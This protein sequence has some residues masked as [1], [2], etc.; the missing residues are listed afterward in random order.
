MALHEDNIRDSD[1][2]IIG[3]V[4][5]FPKANNVEALWNNLRD[6]VESISQFSDAELIAAGIDPELLSQPNYVKANGLLENVDL[7][8]AN[9]FGFSAKEAEIVDPQH[10]LFLECAW[11][12]LENAGYDPETYQGA[13][14]VYAGTGTNSYL[15][16]NLVPMMQNLDATVAFQVF[17]GNDKDFVAT[18]TSYKLNLK[19]P[20]INVSTAC[21]TSLV[22]VH[23]AS[24]S[25]LS[26]ECDMVLVGGVSVRVP[27]KTGYLY[28]QGMIYSPDGHC[29]AFD[30]QS[31][32]TIGGNGVG[33]I[34]LKRLTE[35]IADG[36]Y[37]HAVIKGSAINNDG[38]MK[39]GYTAPSVEGQAAVIAEAQAIAEVDADTITYIEAHGTA[40]DLGDPIEIAA[41]TK[42][43]QQSTDQ[44]GFC[45]IG[46]LK[47]NVGHLDAAAGIAGVIKTVQALKHKQI[48][49]SLHF[50]T[51]NPKIDFANSPFYVNA[52][53][54]EWEAIAPRRAGVS[55]FGI[56]GTNA[57]VI[58]EEAPALSPSGES[59]PYQLL[60]LSAKTAT[61]LNQAQANL[62]SYLRAT[63]DALNLA[64]IAFT[65]KVGRQ[66][67]EHRR[68]LICENNSAKI[69][70]AIAALESN[71]LQ[72]VLSQF[73]DLKT[74]PV[75]MMFSGQ[76][77][78]YVGMGQELYRHEPVFQE[79]LDRCCDL[80]IPHLGLDLRQILYPVAGRTEE[81]QQ[82]LQQTAI[83]QPAI[84]AIEY[85]LAQLWI[86]W[87]VKPQ[88]MIGHSIGEYVAAC[89]AQVFDLED[90]IKLVAAR[91]RLM[92]QLPA[93]A[94]LAVSLSATEIAPFLTPD[95]AIA[96]INTPSSTV[97][98]G[99]LEA[100]ANLEKQL[101]AKELN[102]R[103]LH[104]SHAFH[105]AMMEPMLPDFL[106]L[107]AKVNLHPPQIPYVSNVTG[108]WITKTEA[109]D[110]QYW[111]RHIRQT[112]KFAEGLQ[113]ILKEPQ[114]LL[115]EVG[116][117][118]TLSTLARQQVA[119]SPLNILSSLPHPQDTQSDLAFLFTTLGQLWL[120][121]V[122]IDWT[123]FYIDEDRHRIPLPT[124]PFERQ[125][126]WI[127]PKQ[128]AIALANLNQSTAEEIRKPDIS[129]WFYI[130]AWKQ[131]VSPIAEL[132]LLPRD[133]GWL[134]FVDDCQLSDLLIECLK[135]EQ[136]DITTVTIGSEFAKLGDRSYSINPSQSSN[137][138]NLIRE[139]RDNLQSRGKRL[140]HIIHLWNVNRKQLT[141][142]DVLK[143]EHQVLDLGLHSLIF[144]TQALGN[145]FSSENL[146]IVV[147]SN[148][149]QEVTGTENLCPEKATLLGAV[150]IVPQEYPNIRCRSVDITLGA[151][152]QPNAKLAE[153][154]LREIITP[155]SDVAI[156]YRGNYRW[157]QQFEPRQFPANPL[158]ASN[159]QTP[160]CR[161]RESGV[162]LI[163]GGMGGMGLAFAKYLA[164]TAK[165]KLILIGRS[166]FPDHQDWSNWL[167]TRDEEDE[168]SQKI[169]QL[170]S[171]EALGAE[172][173]AISADVSNLE[174]MQAVITQAE[175]RFGK[176]NG[177]LHAAGVPDYG[178]VIARRDRTTIAP[179]L[180]PKFRGT[181]VLDRLLQDTQLDFLLLCSS[182]SSLLHGIKFG[183]VS[184]CAANDFLDAYAYAKTA[185]DSTFTV[186]IN[187]TDW[188][189]VGMSVNAAKRSPKSTSQN[190]AETMILDGPSP[191]EGV[192]IFKRVLQSPSPRV[193]ISTQDLL[194]LIERYQSLSI[195]SFQEASEENTSSQS[196]HPRPELANAYV[197]PRNQTEQA[198]AKIWQQIIGVDRVGIYDNFFELGGDSLIGLQVIAK[199]NQEFKSNIPVATLYKAPTVGTI[200]EVVN[201]TT[202]ESDPTKQRRDRG[203]RRR[204]KR[205]QK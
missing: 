61:A 29:R 70:E 58:L 159:Y 121:G 3:I 146:D 182:L 25:L 51:P 31:Q 142:D 94:M 62:A 24:Q 86:S 158:T 155:T 141:V 178:G 115:L 69:Q 109:T 188:K 168:T 143:D 183:E 125:S 79:H 185:R 87:G 189:E 202:T 52:K 91:G 148:D 37:I 194:Q 130:P 36:D 131:S 49:P 103:R 162:Y 136:Q 67:F 190:E 104:T 83:A 93:G 68:M 124:Y 56:G 112:V 54:R 181:L 95:L 160:N 169:K 193:A 106:T 167:D 81:A 41:L 14:G 179:A 73:T 150:Q 201:P 6:G 105:S 102:Y 75:T 161:I 16:N 47:T 166:P 205:L 26:G 145:H 76:G 186:A 90:A 157:V 63:A 45:A 44:K 126:Y 174:Q 135:A 195:A 88:A 64:D 117:G 120:A 96:A 82:Q 65:L 170:Q 134:I 184:Y 97:L 98:A 132:S 127:E 33:V 200:A 196:Y 23:L 17:L 9:F 30:A 171:M 172:V 55:S 111:L 60:L 32:G 34:V 154:L 5:R 107:L 139:L 71:D 42:A 2:A 192:E 19:G 119:R 22:V 204:E 100:I 177:V 35:A 197:S 28:Q 129:D 122:P 74:R 152:N 4:G 11:E 165:A 40:T 89:L 85:A 113:Q 77:S 46:S 78:Q 21:S 72:K 138:E 10:R 123:S 39:V 108:T 153:Q 173:W 66:A 7:F 128:T 50:E 140:S 53:L 116:A 57:H 156:A 80:L 13:I 59:R 20:S 114:N 147:I 101:A 92:Q 198:I 175:Q 137:Y 18:R 149:L 187:W 1:I 164:E 118:K 84:F 191:A 176:I 38:A 8:D 43:F 133:L 110:P 27:Q 99:S 15:Y 151:E 48:P 203:E 163:T 12:A 199:L 180:A 144:T